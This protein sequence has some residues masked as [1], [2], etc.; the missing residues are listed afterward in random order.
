MK[1]KLKQDC[2][3]A[4]IYVIFFL[5][6]L[7]LMGTAMYLYSISSLRSVRYLSDKKK[8][9]YLAQA[10]VEASSYAYQLAINSGDSDAVTLVSSTATDE[11]NKNVIN[12]NYVY[13]VYRNG[14]KYVSFA[15]LS[16][17]ND[18]EII[19]CYKVK[20]TTK[21]DVT[22]TKLLKETEGNVSGFEA[23][24]TQIKESQ[25]YFEA[26][27]YA[28]NGKPTSDTVA[29]V[30]QK[31]I[32]S[33]V[34]K[35][36][37]SEPVQALG[38]FY[39]DKDNEPYSGLKSGVIDG[40]VSGKKVIKDDEGNNV[41]VDKAKMDNYEVLG[42]Y[43]TGTELTLKVDLFKNIPLIGKY[44]GISYENK[45][46][47]AS[48]TVPILMAYTTGNMIMNAPQSGTISFKQNQ[49][50]MVSFVGKSNLFLNSDLDVTPSKGYFN[51]MY[52]RGNNI[53]INGDID[54][55]V[56]GFTR[57]TFKLFQNV[58]NIYNAIA[59]NYAWSTVVI[60]TAEQ[61]SVDADDPAKV[62][63]NVY[64]RR[65]TDKNGNEVT[66]TNGSKDGYGM[67]GKVF[68]GGN[69]FIN[70]QVPNVGT[71]R[72]KAF[73]AGDTYYYDDNLPQQCG[74]R[75][76]YGI[77]LFKYFVDYSIATKK[78]SDNVLERF[79]EVMGL[80]YSSSGSNSTPTTY[81]LGTE[82]GNGE[83]DLT[84]CAMR[85]IDRVKY[86]DGYKALIPPTQADDTSLRWVLG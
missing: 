45:I 69:V 37:I 10:G 79:A 54:I 66:G 15:Q 68:F 46:T 2:G 58:T 84:Y 59:G 73:S 6:V 72:Y 44:I 14:Y 32:A 51:I 17:Y 28:L 34:K 40:A 64:R 86:K 36:Y 53:V 18:E 63:A 1:S 25:R 80:Y 9:E 55:Y 26:T 39:N 61:E 22:P 12:T 52:L 57:S 82:T 31:I 7:S 42:K 29:N 13:L 41:N 21:L 67:C 5:F 47:I 8:A 50:N 16:G 43:Q 11:A 75:A 74:G 4:I 30:Q 24:W 71:Y 65:V 85:K 35:A 3:F 27:G 83:E 49:S 19:G 77:D 38:R 33:A 20:I 70:L 76:G 78:Y 48:Q 60:G 56:Y 23:Y 62:Q 81:V